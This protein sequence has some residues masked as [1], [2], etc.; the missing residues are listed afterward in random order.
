[1]NIKYSPSNNLTNSF[2]IHE[3]DDCQCV[4][5]KEIN[6]FVTLIICS[7]V[8]SLIITSYKFT[9]YK[10]T[11]SKI[12]FLKRNFQLLK[13][14]DKTFN[15]FS[16]PIQHNCCNIVLWKFSELVISPLSEC[17]SENTAVFPCKTSAFS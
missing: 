8:N 3:T 12:I 2:T 13:T 7:I 11:I 9:V 14:K 6:I 17:S 10:Y 1:M 16:A 4:I 15:L 5:P